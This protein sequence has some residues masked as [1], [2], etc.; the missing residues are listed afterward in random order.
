[1]KALLAQATGM[2]SPQLLHSYL[3]SV[4]EHLDMEV[5][6]VSRFAEGRRHFR[7]IDS[8]F[9]E[10]E[11]IQVGDSDPLE[12]SFCQRVV[13][14]RLP[15]LIPDAAANDEACTLAATRALPVGAH[16]S[17]PIRL[18]D[19]SVYGIFC[20]FSRRPDHSLG[21]RDL[22]I[23]RVFAE[24]VAEQVSRELNEREREIA[25]HGG[26]DTALDCLQMVFQP[27]CEV[28]DGRVAGFE[29]L[30]RFPALPALRTEAVF[31]EAD[32]IGRGAELELR[33]IALALQALPR[34]PEPLY[35]SINASPATLTHPG[36]APLFAG[37]PLQ[38]LVLEVTEH[39]AVE[40][41]DHL[42]A[43]IRPLQAGGLHLAIDDAG[44]GSASFRH[45]LNLAPHQ[46]KLDISL[47][48]DLHLDRSRY[49]LAAALS[50]F[51][52]TIGC[53]LV[54]EGVESAQ[55]LA[56]LRDLG[57]QRAQGYYLG[58][59]APLAGQLP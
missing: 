1:M 52:R 8:V 56:A 3:R 43:A 24:L 14:G 18:H 17:V 31:A 37:L 50:S 16:L 59:P 58:R 12:E 39:A 23:M 30:A 32:L 41:Y 26:V 11:P 4:R 36:L 57:I 46:I 51:A 35:L 22:R 54:A 49:A 40:H 42:L 13:D 33:A 38:R 29:A 45:V 21:E 19:G 48:R 10:F 53:Q 55:E 20:C 25:A 27:T 5:A 28:G 2:R 44:A 34:L 7:V 15:E 47:T 6:F 9:G